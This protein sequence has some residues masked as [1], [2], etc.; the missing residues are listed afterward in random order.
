LGSL[1]TTTKVEE[2]AKELEVHPSVIIGKLAHDKKISY[3]NIHLYNNNV[4][5]EI[6]EKYKRGYKK[7]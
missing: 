3:R 4:L 2:C 1:L 6:P 7:K 5:V